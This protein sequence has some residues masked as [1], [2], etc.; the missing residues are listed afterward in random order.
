[1]GTGYAEKERE[2]VDGLAADTGRDLDQWMKAISAA[3]PAKRNDIIDWL[4][5]QGFAFPKASWLE[6][7]H[8]NGGR[9]IYA[10]DAAGPSNARRLGALSRTAA[11]VPSGHAAPASG[12]I[13]AEAAVDRLEEHAERAELKHGHLGVS[14]GAEVGQFLAAAKGLKPLAEFVLREIETAVPG[15]SYA[16]ATPYLIIAAPAAFAALHPAPKELRLFADFGAGTGNRVRK[17]EVSAARGAPP[18]P[19]VLIVND[20]RQIDGAFLDLVASAYTRALK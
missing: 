9:L 13:L 20:A 15:I 5:Q 10:D 4:R 7:I 19:E 3:G 16:V 11:V 8:H 1:M 6:R 14:S 17:A 2:F 18:F 12:C